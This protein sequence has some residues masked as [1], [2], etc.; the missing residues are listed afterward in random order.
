MG[1]ASSAWAGR[2]DGPDMDAAHRSLAE[3][4]PR[5]ALARLLPHLER[6][7]CD[8]GAWTLA[9][10]A[11]LGTGAWDQAHA[12]L[13]QARRHAPGALEPRLVRARVWAR[14]GRLERAEA[15]LS[16]ATEASDSPRPAS[17]LG[18]LRVHR[19]RLD[20]A[21]AA[22]T[23]ALRRAPGMVGALAGLATVAERRGDP[24]AVVEA[25]EPVMR[26]PAPPAALA[27]AWGR[28]LHTLGRP[29]PAIPAVERALRATTPAA[30]RADLLYTLA[31]LHDAA[32]DAEAAF[33]A[34]TRANG[35]RPRSFDGP[36]HLD[37]VR[38][39]ARLLP[40]PGGPRAP[41]GRPGRSLLVVGTPRAGTTLTETMLCRHP[42]I[43]AGGEL[44][45]WRHL[46]LEAGEAVGLQPYYREP[47]RI[48]GPLLGRLAEAY[49][50]RLDRIDPRAERVVDKMPNNVLHLGL[51]TWA[52]P[53]TVVVHCVRD[54][55]DA[56]WSCYRLPLGP[57]LGWSQDLVDI[58]HWFR[59]ERELMAHW[60][61]TLPVPIVTVRYE[62]LVTD[63][64]ASLRPVV[65]ACGLPWD[66]A[67][68]RH[69]GSDRRVATASHAQI[70]EPLHRRGVGRSRPYHGPMR[71]FFQA[72]EAFGPLP[73]ADG[74]TRAA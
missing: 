16:D 43:A 40:H 2:S 18:W 37:A 47:Q 60:K 66:P 36:R 5:E 38:T 70:R 15:V 71:A 42:A 3:G 54:P 26:S 20:E 39:L 8:A 72:W 4:R 41:E 45:D 46:A 6:A 33:D 29:G 61:R 55:A 7:P 52:L 58:A 14:Q 12:A 59:A 27:C 50:T 10:R 24:G 35:L 69:R 21:E 56:A 74:V 28:A 62:D 32:G 19:A 68:A 23:L 64:E 48:T 65:E 57:G 11:F 63:P 9:A 51:A 13:D 1:A 17:E 44:E 31:A 53:D 67:V 49:R 25:L 73:A 34:A 30:D 22:F